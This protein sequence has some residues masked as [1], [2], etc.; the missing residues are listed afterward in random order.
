MKE[1]ESTKKMFED[2][3]ILGRVAYALYNL[4]MYIKEQGETSEIWEKIFQKLW[5]FSEMEY[6]DDY[7]YKFVEYSK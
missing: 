4:E 1:N 5:S 3:S 7:M 6:I 2:I